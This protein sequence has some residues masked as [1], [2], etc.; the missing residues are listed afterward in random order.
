MA[1]GWELLKIR[2]AATSNVWQLVMCALQKGLGENKA[3]EIHEELFLQKADGWWMSPS[4]G[5]TRIKGV[6]K[7]ISLNRLACEAL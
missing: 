1:E 4:P 3:I 5:Q 2:A 7:I 6:P